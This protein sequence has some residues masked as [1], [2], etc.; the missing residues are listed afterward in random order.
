M[1]FKVADKWNERSY[2]ADTREEERSIW[3]L[4]LK[5]LNEIDTPQLV[6][7]GGYESRCLARMRKRYPEYDKEQKSV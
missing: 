1:R 6:H 4:C 7:Y 2:W 5:T 3:K